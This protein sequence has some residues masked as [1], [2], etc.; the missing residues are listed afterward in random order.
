[1]MPATYT[2]QEPFIDVDVSFLDQKMTLNVERQR[3]KIG[4]GDIARALD[5]ECCAQERCQRPVAIGGELFAIIGG[6]RLED[7]DHYQGMHGYHLMPIM[8]FPGAIADYRQIRQGWS[9]QAKRSYTGLVVRMP[10]RSTYVMAEEVDIQ[11]AEY[12]A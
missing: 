7:S 10:D 5:A 4:K 9:R 6:M 12:P 1:M 8:D 11:P 2:I 3:L